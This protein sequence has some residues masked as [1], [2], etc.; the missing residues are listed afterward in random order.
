MTRLFLA[1]VC[2]ILFI[3]VTFADIEYQEHS[4]D[5]H[6]HHHHHDHD[7]HDHHDHES[8]KK[9]FT[10][11]DVDGSDDEQREKLREIAI[12]IDTDQDGQISFNEM[13]TYVQERIKDQHNREADE[14]IST[15]DPTNTNKITFTAYVRD[16]Y[17][18]LDTNQLEKMDKTDSRSRETRRTFSSDKQKWTHLDKDGDQILSYD[19]FRRFLRPEDDEEL[20]Q[21]EINSIIKEYD[22]NKD[23]KISNDEYSKMTEA[24]TGQAESLSEEL[25]T[26]NDGFGEYEEFDRYYLPTSLL[27]TD[28]ETEHLL[29]EC[30]V[31]KK[32]YCT[33]NEIV[34]AYSSF[35]GS[36]ITDFGADLETSKEEL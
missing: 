34:N 29:K 3:V 21:I 9:L 19:E 10:G 18:D 13:R 32:G 1:A 8:H 20:R 2:F 4:H 23:G 35:A 28:E 16:N 14:F 31:E 12:K 5:D 25:D 11:G 24:E 26:N 30:D 33:P 27:T 22:E 17:G 7:G 6:H 36:Q 15:L